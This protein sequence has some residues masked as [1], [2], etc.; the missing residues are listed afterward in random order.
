MT[1]GVE[2]PLTLEPIIEAVREGV[3]D[4]GFRPIAEWSEDAFVLMLAEA[5]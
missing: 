5:V 1:S 3:E 4:A 2:L